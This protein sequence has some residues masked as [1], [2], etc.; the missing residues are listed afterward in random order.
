MIP[1][2][3]YLKGFMSYRDEAALSF[4]GASLWV[5][6]GRNGA[7]KS[8]I[9]DAITFALYGVHRGGSQH[10]KDLINH[11]AD[12]FEVEFDFL[13]DGTAY[14][15]KRTVSRR[16]QST[17]QAFFLG[18]A[19]PE[20]IPGTDGDQGFRDWIE[21]IIGLEY[22]TFTASVLLLQGDSEKL[23]NM[24]SGRRHDALS[25]LID[26]SPYERLHKAAGE[27]RQHHK[28]LAEEY[29]NRLQNTPA[30]SDEELAAAE[31][32][33]EQAEK[34][35]REAGDQVERLVELVGHAREW[36][37]LEGDLAEQRDNA[38]KARML[39][40][41]EEEIR[42]GFDRLRLL[43]Q[44]L[45]ATES[46]VEKKQRLADNERYE[47][48][49]NEKR[50]GIEGDLE[51]ATEEK[52]VADREVE[53]LTSLVSELKNADAGLADLANALLPKAE[54]LKRLEEAQAVWEEAKKNLD[55]LP[56]D[57]EET[58]GY[59]EEEVE[60]LA[61]A[62]RALPWLE[63]LARARFSLSE[64][65]LVERS[66][67]E[68]LEALR[69]RLQECEAEC[70]RLS[71][72]AKAA[73][74]EKDEL[75]HDVTRAQARYDDASKRRASFDDVSAQ[76]TCGLCGQEI[77]QEHV[78]QETARLDARLAETNAEL[79]ASKS[80]HQRAESRLEALE[81]ELE[82][83]EKAREAFL[84]ERD[85]LEN[86]REQAG[87]NVRRHTKQAEDSFNNLPNSYQS[88][89]TSQISEGADWTATTY[90][91]D[92]ELE[93]LKREM[94]GKA[95]H[96]ERLRE[97][98]EQ[99]GQKQRWDGLC[100]SARRQV[101]NLL[102]TLSWDEARSA[103]DN[104]ETYETR[105][106][107]LR[108]EITQLEEAHRQATGEAKK[109]SE[110]V[111]VLHHRLQESKTELNAL[112]AAREEIERALRA[113]LERLPEDWRE[114]AESAEPE[115]LEG[116][117]EE[118]D[119]LDKYETLFSEMQ[120]AIRSMA[121]LDKRIEELCALIAEVPE[122]ARRPSE[123]VEEELSRGRSRSEDKDTARRKAGEL[124]GELQQGR[125]RRLELEN[126]RREAERQR[127]AYDTLYSL[128]GPRG[129]QGRLL[130][131]AEQDL[132]TLAN[133]TLDGLSR[134]RMRLELRKG[135]DQ[136]GALD[137]VVLDSSTGSNPVAVSLTSGSQ[138]FRIAV[139]LA[140]AIG[141]YK[142]QQ[143]RRIQ[144]VIIDEGFGSLDK[145]SRDDMIQVL[146]DLQQELDRII[147]VS[148]QE[149]FAN[150]FTNG[151]AVSLEDDSSRVESLQLS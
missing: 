92:P 73:R 118:R 112:Q 93:E 86:E 72:G 74:K 69:P 59:A 15:V 9:F 46:I 47:A 10:A 8:A 126:W 119:E 109:R 57:L 38:E 85:R 5:L 137:L 148:H 60:R 28:S 133:E 26:L 104:L 116:W 80:Q 1:L 12:R 134:G 35:W 151:Y 83:A 16:G 65:L 142:G 149:E 63:Q 11:H 139:S 34:E 31:N 110:A 150:A 108:V 55:A 105:R 100:Q 98:R 101:S 121:D 66:T 99:L 76:P 145:N 39:L 37:R 115:D 129:L 146:N 64:A 43:E 131:V 30:V 113:D 120:N 4:D 141:R 42:A 14:R 75:S 78:E 97:L 147:L 124:F 96:A 3:I 94:H 6:S 19:D 32:A 90:P 91:A 27:R 56:P 20:P 82:E 18:S 79:E 21:D 138:R 81:N 41:R 77:T 132:V 22:D 23:L 143:A 117:H 53:R 54:H 45:P 127:R 144:S 135:D 58:I 95:T 106:R 44:V 52:E 40:G 114:Q 87:Q 70:E 140:L 130:R 62:E 50:H 122:E 107:E 33:A 36:R 2:R 71:T 125:D 17:R 68:E 84:K 67:S 48:E 111:N 25:E 7:G 88:R 24:R 123:E 136:R 29:G 61:E 128:L 103:R 89:V 49:A 13:M 51:E 102:E